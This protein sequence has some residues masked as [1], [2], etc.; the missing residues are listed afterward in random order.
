ML[1]PDGEMRD[2]GRDRMAGGGEDGLGGH[3]VL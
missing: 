1:K 3:E 2:G